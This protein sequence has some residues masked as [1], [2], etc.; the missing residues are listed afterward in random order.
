MDVFLHISYHE[1]LV[2][3]LACNLVLNFNDGLYAGREYQAHFG[4]AFSLNEL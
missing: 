1:L 3:T 2:I 4:P